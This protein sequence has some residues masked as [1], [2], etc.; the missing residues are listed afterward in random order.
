MDKHVD[1]KIKKRKKLFSLVESKALLAFEKRKKCYSLN[2]L[3]NLIP[4]FV[5]LCW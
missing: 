5:T 2:S 1:E 3:Y 4:A